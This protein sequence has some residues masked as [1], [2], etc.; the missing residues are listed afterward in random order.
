[1]ECLQLKT[2]D[3]G[4]IIRMSNNSPPNPPPKN[5][6]LWNTIKKYPD[7]ILGI[8]L[9]TIIAAISLYFNNYSSIRDD[10]KSEIND[11]KI[12]LEGY[13]TTDMKDDLED[14]KDD[15][16]SVKGRIIALE[17]TIPYIKSNNGLVLGS[18]SMAS[19]MEQVIATDNVVPTTQSIPPTTCIGSDINGDDLMAKDYINSPLLFTYKEGNLDVIFFGTYNQNF[20]WDGYCVTNAY[21]P[22]GTLYSICESNFEDGIRLNYKTLYHPNPDDMDA[23]LLTNRK[24]IT[25]SNESVVTIGTSISYK[26]NYN[27]T[28][29]FTLE[30]AQISDVKYIESFIELVNPVMT[31]YYSGKASGANADD[32]TGH[33]YEIIFNDDG[34]VKILYVGKF[35]NGTFNDDT[36]NGW[37]IAYSENENRY[38]YNNNCTFTGGKADIK[39]GGEPIDEIKAREIVENSDVQFGIRLKWKNN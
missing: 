32:D 29:N 26:F 17:T 35:A 31:K 38:Y 39:L 9:G 24:C 8:T 11:L 3:K 1:M 36:T 19:F 5:H 22:D 23:W 2:K 30:N 15:I 18:S 34:T 12:I 28:K 21:Y 14:I 7:T 4:D 13:D 10:V 27:K 20:N 37:M 6:V 16:V 25:N 33:A